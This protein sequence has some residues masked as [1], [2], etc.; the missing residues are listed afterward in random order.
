MQ[1]VHKRNSR[2]YI[3][4]MYSKSQYIVK[5]FEE[6]GSKLLNQSKYYIYYIYIY[7]EDHPCVLSV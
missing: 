2:N 4:Q 7:S 6:C 5:Y 3:S 1:D